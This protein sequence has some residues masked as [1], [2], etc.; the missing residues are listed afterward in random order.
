MKF[1]LIESLAPGTAGKFYRFDGG[2]D[3]EFH[4]ITT[5]QSVDSSESTAE[6]KANMVA[7]MMITPCSVVMGYADISFLHP[8]FGPS[9]STATQVPPPPSTTTDS[10]PPVAETVPILTDDEGGE[11]VTLVD[12]DQ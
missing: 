12:P 6:A 9:G 3:A 7:H 11:K 5:W 10:A 4:P 2:W 8:S 1:C